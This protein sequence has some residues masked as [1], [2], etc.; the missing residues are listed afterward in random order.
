MV[1]LDEK[2][3]SCDKKELS[4]NICDKKLSKKSNLK[5]HLI[6]HLDEGPF[7]CDICKK[8]F[9]YSVTLKSHLNIHQ[10]NPFNLWPLPG[11]KDTSN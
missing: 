3:F 7:S 10:E 9:K 5:R 1:Y 2:P 4:C 6:T 8:S 11:Y